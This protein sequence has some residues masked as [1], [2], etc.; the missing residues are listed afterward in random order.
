MR[1]DHKLITPRNN[2]VTMISMISILSLMHF[3]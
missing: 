2:R 1:V 3:S